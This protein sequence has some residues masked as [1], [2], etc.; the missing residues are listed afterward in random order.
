MISPE[1]TGTTVRHF[2]D[3]GF[4][5]AEGVLDFGGV[6]AGAAGEF[7]AAAA[8]ASDEGGDGLDDL[9]GL[10]LFGEVR[11]DGA[12]GWWRR[13]LINLVVRADINQHENF[14]RASCFRFLSKN[15]SAVI[16]AGTCKESA[17]LPL[18]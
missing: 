7:G 8:F 17:S 12:V 16:T 9:A 10:D 2:G 6:F 15:D 14:L 3:E 4:G 11:G 13:N 1:W 18:R 5:F